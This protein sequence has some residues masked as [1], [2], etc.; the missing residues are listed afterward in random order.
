MLKNTYKDKITSFIGVLIMLHGLS[1]Y[2]FSWPNEM[3]LGVN[4]LEVAIG[5][6]LLFVDGRVIGEAVMVYLKKK[7]GIK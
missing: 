2:M 6:M 5:F 3:N 1:S 4:A 7:L